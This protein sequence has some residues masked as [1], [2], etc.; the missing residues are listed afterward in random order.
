MGGGSAEGDNPNRHRKVQARR[1]PRHATEGRATEV[2]SPRRDRWCGRKTRIEKR[3]VAR[4]A[5]RSS[6]QNRS[7]HRPTLE[8]SSAYRRKA[9]RV[10]FSIALLH[11][12]SGLGDLGQSERTS[13]LCEEGDEAPSGDRGV[14]GPIRGSS[15]GENPWPT[16]S[17]SGQSG[18][19]RRETPCPSHRPRAQ[20]RKLR[21]RAHEHGCSRQVG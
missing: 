15:R 2:T 8:S 11:G 5:V 1:S 3:R 14:R 17:R 6:P 4:L 16:L 7:R 12:Q 9:P 20:A 13:I 10:A 18:Q 21:A 19:R